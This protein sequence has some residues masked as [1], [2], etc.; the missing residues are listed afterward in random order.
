MSITTGT[1][2]G[3]RIVDMPDLGAVTDTSSVVGEHAGSGRFSATALRTYV[4]MF[5]AP[6]SGAVTRSFTSRMA[7]IISVKDYGAKGDNI[8]DDTASCQAAINHA[9]AVGGEVYFPAGTYKITGAGLLINQTVTTYA[10]T[11]VNIRGAG[12]GNTLLTYNGTGTCLKYTGNTTGAGIIG[13]FSI[14]H[15]QIGGPGPAT[16]AIGLSISIAAYC[17]IRDVSILGCS[18]GLVMADCVSM[19]CEGLDCMGNHAGCYA[20][21][22][23]QTPPNALT[24]VRCTLGA[25]TYLG[26]YVTD[27]TALTVI[28]GSI[29]SN[30]NMV[31]GGAGVLLA[32]SGDNGGVACTLTGVYFEN[33]AKDADILINH[34]AAA[35]LDCVYNVIGCN[36]NRGATTQYTTNN[37]QLNSNAGNAAAMLNVIGCGFRG[38]PPYTP[39]AARPYIALNGGGATNV[40]FTGLGNLYSSSVERPVIQG[41]VVTQDAVATA[42][43]RF[44]GAGA[45][46]FKTPQQSFNAG[47]N[48]TGTGVYVVTFGK[49]MASATNAYSAQ[50]IGGIGVAYVTAETAN[51]VTIQ[52]T[53]T[54]GGA[55]DFQ[56]AVT[57]FGGGNVV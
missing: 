56:V 50:V 11:R 15:L 31:D 18:Y 21:H 16:T 34:T 8:A 30:G 2:P 40:N 37:I 23:V 52:T 53:N 28:G 1:F 36:F 44:D 26:L 4:G 39:S 57:V 45:T 51:S 22:D 5:T 27:A 14:S 7:D 47:V 33:N 32:S 29:E 17:S 38:F 46:G 24:F 6:G 42:W 13:L 20:Y 10:P 35:G 54:S 48:K 25:N 3:V 9:L 43:V 12:R 41:P 19:L 55:T 49:A